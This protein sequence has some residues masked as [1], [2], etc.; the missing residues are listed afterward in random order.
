M[1][2]MPR[3][4]IGEIREAMKSQPVAIVGAGTMGWQIA[5]VLATH[6]ITIHLHDVSPG[7]L[8]R[9]MAILAEEAPRLVAAGEL[10]RTALA[11]T[12]RVVPTASLASAVAG[13]WLVIETVP[14]RLELKRAVFA[15]L[16]TF[17]APETIL[18]TNSSSYRSRLLADATRHPERLLNAHFYGRPWR[19]PAVELMSCGMTEPALLDRLA[20]FF[21]ACGLEPFIARAE[22]TGLIFN[23]IWRAV[24]RES[25]RVVEEGIATPEEVDR[26]WEIV[27]GTE[28]MGPFA[29]MD[30]VGLD[31]VLDIERTYWS[32]SGDPGD[33]PPR[34]LEALVA[35]GRL[36]T[37][38][39]Q[40][41]YCHGPEPDASNDDGTE[42]RPIAASDVTA[43]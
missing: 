33:Q 2:T 36:G 23:R 3:V 39:G 43:P 37:K 30:R 29:R 1:I 41:F 8:D 32:E 7:A 35:Q 13:A 18:A 34:L 38:T 21:R 10:P 17:A 6:E 28:R 5:L 24:K 22:S 4:R 9:A 12:E 16:S 19:R 26:L 27:M 25:L 42:S 31:V 14:E 11:A 40:G 15:E 20:A